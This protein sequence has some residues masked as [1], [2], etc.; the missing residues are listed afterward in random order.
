MDP[1]QKLAIEQINGN[2]HLFV[3]TVNFKL[4]RKSKMKVVPDVNLRLWLTFNFKNRV[5]Y[6]DPHCFSKL[7]SDPDQH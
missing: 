2:S 6:P 4:T 7:D 1:A 5:A 3:R